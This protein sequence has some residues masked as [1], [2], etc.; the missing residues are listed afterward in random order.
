[1]RVV[2]IVTTTTLSLTV[3]PTNLATLI[4][5]RVGGWEG[6]VLLFHGNNTEVL[7]LGNLARTKYLPVP[8]ALT[9]Y[10]VINRDKFVNGGLLY[11]ST[12]TGTSPV[13]VT[14]CTVGE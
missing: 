12:D 10:S 7:R 13:T 8:T 14:I 5:D 3:T 6:L 2:D 1:M 11:L 4:P 9:E